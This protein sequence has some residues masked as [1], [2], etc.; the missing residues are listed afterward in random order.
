M[1]TAV[2]FLGALSTVLLFWIYFM[3]ERQR[4]DFEQVD[5]IMDIQVRTATFH[6]WFEE[7]ITKG[8]KVDVERTFGD[9][10]AA[11]KFS[12]A[13]LTGGEDENGTVLVPF[14][15]PALLDYARS[16]RSSL[17]RLKEIA[18]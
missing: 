5:D 13:L 17:D 4:R 9:L 2:F 6:L 11:M 16:I 15:D 10:D 18:L 8:T 14:E 12:D 7:A 1:P 3:G